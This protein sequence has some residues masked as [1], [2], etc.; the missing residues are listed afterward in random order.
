MRFQNRPRQSIPLNIPR[1]TYFCFSIETTFLEIFD[2]CRNQVLFSRLFQVFKWCFSGSPQNNLKI[3]N[4]DGFFVG[5][6]VVALIWGSL[7]WLK[8]RLITQAPP[9]SGVDNTS[10]L[11]RQPCNASA[12]PYGSQ[13]VIHIQI[14]SDASMNPC[15]NPE[16]C[17]A[18][19]RCHLCL[20]DVRPAVK[21]FL[22]LG[23]VGAESFLLNS[24]SSQEKRV[25]FF[26]LVLLAECDHDRECGGGTFGQAGLQFKAIPGPRR[27]VLQ[28]ER[29]EIVGRAEVGTFINGHTTPLLH[30]IPQTYVSMFWYS[31]RHIAR[32][33]PRDH[34]C[35][36]HVR[37]GG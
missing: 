29:I 16:M 21:A 18:C 34:L 7:G 33:H 2:F 37:P 1:G 17:P 3:D 5:P 20:R 26:E 12:L 24:D 23:M 36:H 28:H 14:M 8:L 22:K 25:R 10:D 35:Y 4:S 13:E 11:H 6:I 30:P 32:L 19:K 15:I 31:A 27:C 9:R